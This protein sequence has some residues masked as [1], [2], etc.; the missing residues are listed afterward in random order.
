MG[1]QERE[2]IVIIFIINLEIEEFW[3]AK[4]HLKVIL[5]AHTYNPSAL[6]EKSR[7]VVSLRL[8]WAR[9]QIP[10]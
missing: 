2:E 10:R 3:K 7:R 8:A 6:G 1:R 5:V 9:N 4:G